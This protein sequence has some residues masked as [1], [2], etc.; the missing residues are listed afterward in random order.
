MVLWLFLSVS[1]FLIKVSLHPSWTLQNL[2]NIHFVSLGHDGFI[3]IVYLLH[4]ISTETNLESNYWY[5]GYWV[6]HEITFYYLVCLI[7]VLIFWKVTKS[8]VVTVSG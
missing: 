4:E 8:N 5:P 3:I 2:P 6:Y 1:L 7:F